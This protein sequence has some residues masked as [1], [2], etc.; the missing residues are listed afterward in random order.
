MG[1]NS[2]HELLERMLRAGS[3]PLAVEQG[4]K[5][6]RKL[7]SLIASGEGSEQLSIR[8]LG[9]RAR[10][11]FGFG[12][13]DERGVPTVQDIQRGGLAAAAGLR[14]G[15]IVRRVNGGELLFT[16]E[17]AVQ[18]LRALSGT[19]VTLSV[20]RPL[21]DAASSSSLKSACRWSNDALLLNAGEQARL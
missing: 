11:G 4:W 14:P 6:S 19:E 17:S 15:D 10:G 16:C 18:A 5:G 2:P 9:G 20:L 7:H 3:V 1:S 8:V 12:L 13:T 21:E